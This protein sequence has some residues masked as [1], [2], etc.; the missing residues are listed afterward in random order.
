MCNCGR[1]S[2]HGGIAAENLEVRTRP[3]R[4]NTPVEFEYVGQTAMTVRG[5]FSGLR[6]RFHYPGARL[7]IDPRDASSLAALPGLRAVQSNDTESRT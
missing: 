4:Q 5:P 6:Y 3:A 2:P 1:Q 7:Q